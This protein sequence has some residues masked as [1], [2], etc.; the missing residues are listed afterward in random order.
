MRK[1]ASM[2]EQGLGTEKD[3]A[4]ANELYKKAASIGYSHY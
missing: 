1:L 4:K 2:Y 3:R